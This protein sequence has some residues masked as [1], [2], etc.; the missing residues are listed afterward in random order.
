MSARMAILAILLLATQA[1]AQGTSQ[2]PKRI[3][4]T[5]PGV[6][7]GGAVATQPSSSPFKNPIGQGVPPAVSSTPSRNQ[8]QT[9][10]PLK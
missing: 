3:N 1:L 7:T 9:A 6:T 5:H 10:V 8:N 2:E 4:R